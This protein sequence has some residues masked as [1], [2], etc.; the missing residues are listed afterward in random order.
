MP[1]R[2]SARREGDVASDRLD[3]ILLRAA[4]WVVAYGRHINQMVAMGDGLGDAIWIA[5]ERR[6]IRA[7]VFERDRGRCFYCGA[8]AVVLDHVIPRARGGMTVEFNLVACCRTCNS[9][10]GAR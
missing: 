2:R 5:A 8:E 6:E 10:K 7:A 4:E 9:I 1:R 3:A